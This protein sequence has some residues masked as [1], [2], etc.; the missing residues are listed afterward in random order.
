MLCGV[1]STYCPR[2]L[3]STQLLVAVSPDPRLEMQ[4][5]ALQV[6]RRYEQEAK[7]RLRRINMT[8]AG[9][10]VTA[11]KKP[12]TTDDAWYEPERTGQML[13]MPTLKG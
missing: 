10:E 1:S 8:A 11:P 5:S 3:T 12:N 4:K 7:E 9:L 13:E 2:I 6:A